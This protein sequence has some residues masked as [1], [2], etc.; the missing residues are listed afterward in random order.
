MGILQPYQLSTR[1]GY[2]TYDYEADRAV[3]TLCWKHLDLSTPKTKGG[4]DGGSLYKCV[5]ILATGKLKHALLRNLEC[6]CLRNAVQSWKFANAST[7]LAFFAVGLMQCMRILGGGA[8]FGGQV[9]TPVLALVGTQMHPI[10]SGRDEAGSDTT[11]I[12]NIERSSS[13]FQTLMP[14]VVR[15]IR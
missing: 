13:I 15:N 7:S 14:H 3:R 6:F 5:S 8:R 4:G 11:K 9:H 10:S 1:E 2:R 12:S